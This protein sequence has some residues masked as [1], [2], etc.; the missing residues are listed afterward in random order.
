MSGGLKDDCEREVLRRK[1]RISGTLRGLCSLVKGPSLLLHGFGL[2]GGGVLPL[3]FVR[4]NAEVDL[5]PFALGGRFDEAADGGGGEALST[6]QSGDIRLAED[7]A[8]VDLIIA[9]VSDAK[10]GEL[11]V[12]DELQGDVLDEVLDLR[13]DFF[14]DVKFCRS[15]VGAS[16]NWKF[17][18]L[19]FKLENFV[20]VVLAG[21][22]LVKM[23]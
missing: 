23:R 9:G 10:F 16:G 6:D 14:H 12:A 8:E 18:V 19:S 11:G 1:N 5:H 2:D 15:V 13:G 4:V 22:R 20:R 7:E 21:L 17:E 3:L